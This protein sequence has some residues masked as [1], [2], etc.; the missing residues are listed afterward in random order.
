MI[1]L[2]DKGKF[3]DSQGKLR[4][5]SLFVDFEYN[6]D[7]S[8]YSWQDKD[9]TYKGVV[10]PSLGRLFVEAGDPTEYSFV[11]QYLASWEHWLRLNETKLIR[12]YIDKWRIELEIALRSRAI[13]SIRDMKDNFQAQRFIVE[14]GWDKGRVGRPN[15]N[16]TERD[17]AIEDRIQD[18]LKDVVTR[19]DRYATPK[20]LA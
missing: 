19:M 3:Y 12:P 10:Y 7:L 11:K 1:P 15:K 2:V 4:T 17:Q 14:A 8:L 16:N 5:Q 18:E 13:L 6:S 20:R 9:R